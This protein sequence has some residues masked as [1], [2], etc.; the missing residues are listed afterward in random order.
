[1][2]E[3]LPPP[4]DAD[5]EMTPQEIRRARRSIERP[6][7]FAQAGSKL[8]TTV[9]IALAVIQGDIVTNKLDLE[10]SKPIIRPIV[11]SPDDEHGNI[12]TV[13]IDGFGNQNGSRTAAILEKP[14]QAISEGRLAAVQQEG[15]GIGIDAVAREIAAMAAK[16]GVSSVPL[17]GYS[18]GGM[19]VLKVAAIL[20]DTYNIDVPTIILD[21]VPDGADSIKPGMRGKASG[22]LSFV[23]ASKNICIDVQYSRI[24]RAIFNLLSPNDTSQLSGSTT[25]FLVSQLSM[26]ISADTKND[27]ANLAT[28]SRPK[29]VIVY[30]T[31]S[32]PDS[33]YFI[34]LRQASDNFRQYAADNGL[35]FVEISVDGAVHSR[36]DKS[37]PE[38]QEAYENAASVISLKREQMNQ[39]YLFASGATIR[40]HIK[41]W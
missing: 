30:V 13:L 37:V 34:K 18:L 12:E 27:M 14:I 3:L 23:E 9:M 16:D 1:M 21:H 32:N 10:S 6:M 40:Y 8:F 31:S 25:P 41:G 19:E 2:S 24:A 33:D 5:Y 22:F 28:D 17:Y 11:P 38:Y 35:E 4:A 20:R 39:D 29:P 15:N 36:P 7:R 26:G